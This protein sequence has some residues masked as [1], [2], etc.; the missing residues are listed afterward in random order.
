M[1]GRL[2]HLL[3]AASGTDRLQAFT[4]LCPQLVKADSASAT[5]SRVVE[6]FTDGTQFPY[7]VRPKLECT[8]RRRKR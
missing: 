5:S 6:A 4:G 2:L 1:S 8:S 3:T 7:R